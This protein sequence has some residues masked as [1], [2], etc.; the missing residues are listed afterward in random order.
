M[1]SV[2]LYVDGSTPKY[3]LNELDGGHPITDISENDV[4]LIVETILN[5]PSDIDIDELKIPAD[6]MNPAAAVIYTELKKQF[7]AL[8]KK[9]NQI[10]SRLDKNFADA[11][12]YY[13]DESL[14]MGLLEQSRE[15]AV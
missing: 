8:S 15:E 11:E 5:D 1:A 9:R 2:K 7:E 13:R 4:L 12:A 3:S 6:K 10:V 14:K